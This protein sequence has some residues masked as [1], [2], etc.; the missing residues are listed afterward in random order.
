MADI[1]K[2]LDLV[3]HALLLS[4][5]RV[6]DDSSSKWTH[7]SSSRIASTSLSTTCLMNLLPLPSETA[8]VNLGS[9]SRHKLPGK[10]LAVLNGSV[11][12]SWR[13]KLFEIL[14]AFQSPSVTSKSRSWMIKRHP[15]IDLYTSTLQFLSKVLERVAKHSII[16]RRPSSTEIPVCLQEASLLKKQR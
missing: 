5:I 2:T 3:Q 16:W 7:L 1:F 6:H 11:R 4:Q 13:T 8:P 14:A 9:M 15:I 10:L 12:I